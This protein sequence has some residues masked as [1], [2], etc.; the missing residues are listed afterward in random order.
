MSGSDEDR[1]STSEASNHSLIITK[2]GREHVIEENYMIDEIDSGA[3]DD[4]C[5]DRASVVRF[6]E[7]DGITKDFNSK[8]GMDFSSLKQFKYI[9]A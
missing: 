4:S 6:N 8:V 9:G 5:N 2:M 7:E 1:A 3:E